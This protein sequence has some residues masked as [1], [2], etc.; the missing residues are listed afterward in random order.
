M[1]LVLGM[2]SHLTAVLTQFK[3][4]LL[5]SFC[6]KF[7]LASAVYLDSAWGL[8]T[9]L[10]ELIPG[11]DCP[12][13][14]EYFDY[15]FWAGVLSIINAVLTF[16]GGPV[17]T[18][19]AVCVF[20]QDLVYPSRR[21]FGSDWAGSFTSSASSPGYA[22]IVRT[23]STTFN[24]DYVY[25]Y[26]FYQNGLVE[27]KVSLG[28]YLQATH[29]NS[30]WNEAEYSVRIQ[31]TAVGTLHDHVIGYKI[32]LDVAGTG[33]T[34]KMIHIDLETVNSPYHDYPITQKKMTTEVLKS[35]DVGGLHMNFDR[36][37]MFVVT[38]PDELNKW[39]VE[40]GY[41]VDPRS[42]LK[43]VAGEDPRAVGGAFAKYQVAVTKHKDNENYI[44]S[45]FCQ[46]NPPLCP[47]TLD[48]YLDGDNLEDEDLVIWA[49]A[50]LMH[51]PSSEDAPTT[52]LLGHAASIF[53][54]PFNYFDEDPAMAIRTGLFPQENSC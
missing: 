8:G 25:D 33:N 18:L 5:I 21:H 27:T 11:A 19:N 22:L 24:Y 32:D 53:I 28:G 49:T 16:P 12:H 37:T 54:R 10:N 41:K 35:D 44:D 6:T 47:I 29:Y 23:I 20:E 51:V 15:T 14:A 3:V 39:G 2:H 48:D 9:S 30:G 46:M 17:T 4:L 31:E 13:T 7:H 36:P 38:N 45:L 43:R 42:P 1:K 34:F 26:V 50:G 40:K 52:E